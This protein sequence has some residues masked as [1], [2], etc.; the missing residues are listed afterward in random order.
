[1]QSKPIHISGFLTQAVPPLVLGR[2]KTSLL[3]IQFRISGLQ[4]ANIRISST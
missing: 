3:R 4:V 2:T 1:M